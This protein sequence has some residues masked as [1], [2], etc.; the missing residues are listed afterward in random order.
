MKNPHVQLTEAIFE[1]EKTAYE[2][3]DFFKE[4]EAK[5]EEYVKTRDDFAERLKYA[6]PPAKQK[7][8]LLHDDLSLKIEKGKQDLR[9]YLHACF[10]ED[11][12]VEIEEPDQE[13][14]DAAFEKA[15]IAH[16][17]IYIVYKHLRPELLEDFTKIATDHLTPEE[18]EEFFDNVRQREAEELNEILT[19]VESDGNALVP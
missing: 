13:K 5:L 6:L 15:R 8:Q 4:S 10:E 17:R 18:I 1:I 12:R 9:K 16:E 11:G 14:L 19:S 7:M 3:D 2:T